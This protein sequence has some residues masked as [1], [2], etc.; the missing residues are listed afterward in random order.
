MTALYHQGHF[1]QV[2]AKHVL[3]PGHVMENY[4]ERLGP[5]SAYATWVVGSLYEKDTENPLVIVAR[6]G[7]FIC[8]VHFRH[9]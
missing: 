1:E 4:V 6:Q 3:E 9:K 8:I 7:K 5:D 2:S